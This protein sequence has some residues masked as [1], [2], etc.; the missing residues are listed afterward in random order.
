VACG[1]VLFVPCALC[2][3]YFHYYTALLYFLGIELF[4]VQFYLLTT[5]FVIYQYIKLSDSDRSKSVMSLCHFFSGYNNESLQT[6]SE[7]VKMPAVEC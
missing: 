2:A 6:I 1:A 3:V 4:H 7:F 5:F